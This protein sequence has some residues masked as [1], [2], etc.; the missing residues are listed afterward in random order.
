MSSIFD[1]KTDV[2]ELSSANQGTSRASYEQIAPTRDCTTT[3]FPNG[4]ISF[5]WSNSGTS[6]WIPSRS[7]LR[8]RCKLSKADGSQLDTGDNIAP[9]MN[10]CAGLFQNMEFRIGGKTVSRCSDFVPQ[11]DALENRLSKSKSWLE[12]IGASTN[13]WQKDFGAR[14]NDVVSDGVTYIESVND[15]VVT[16][17]AMG[18]DAA[19]GGDANSA[20]AAAYDAGTGII[21]FTQNG[22]GAL[23]AD[24]GTSFP[25][26]SYFQYTELETQVDGV[27]NVPMKVIEHINATSIRVEAIGGVDVAEDGRTDFSRITRT[28]Q[29]TPVG[30]KVKEFEITWNPSALSVMKLTSGLPVGD[31]ELILNP[32]PAS[33]YQKF[34]IESIVQNKASTDFKF[35]IEDLY[36]YTANVEGP[37]VSNLNY[38]LDLESCSAQSDK[39]NGIAFQQRNF[40]VNKSTYALTVAYQD[41]RIGS[42]TRMSPSKFRVHNNAGTGGIGQELNLSRFFI[43]YAGVSKPSPDANLSFVAGTDYTTQRYLE[44]QIQS[45]AY[46][47]SGGAETIQEYQDR[48]SYYYFVWPRD[49]DDASTRV[50]VN[51]GFKDGTDVEHMRMLLFSHH[52]QVA[53]ISIVDGRIQDVALEDA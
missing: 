22:G 9:N 51:S 24:V 19:G 32:Q 53:R 8:F 2:A 29:G 15:V 16:R 12:S 3:N 45:G 50:Q 5:K 26:D 38:L 20:N 18:F 43:N 34:A 21:T 49:G 27:L 14:Q 6:W 23:P 44:S 7:Y 52:K 48:G 30:R 25:L 39:I 31:Y 10:M 46:H 13:F 40:E 33:V 41:G 28:P 17:D 11:I 37:R 1:L 4:Q 42:D 35:E 47:D 36:F